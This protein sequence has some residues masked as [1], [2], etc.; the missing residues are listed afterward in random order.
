MP[1][2]LL[3]DLV[4]G[5]LDRV[6]DLARRHLGMDLS[7]VA[8][9]TE[10]KQVYRALRGDAS[11]FGCTLDDGP[12]L[13]ETYCRL[14]V[15]GEIPNA[16]PDTLGQALVRDLRVTAD[17]GIGSYVGVPIRLADGTLFGSFCCV[18]RDA[19]PVDSRDA[20]FL[21]M[22]AE[23]IAEQV[24]AQ[25][26]H[27]ASRHHIG[28]LLEG[29]GPQIAL[30]PI[31]DVHHGRLVGVEALSRFPV[32]YGPPDA[33]FAAAH[34]AGLGLEMERLAARRALRLLPLLGRDHYLAV[35]L[36]PS[37]A[38]DLAGRVADFPDVPYHRLVLEIT[39]HAAVQGYA[40]LRDR[41]KLARERGLRLAIDDAG[42]GY[43]SL[44]HVVELA[45]DIIKIDRS[46]VDGMATDKARRSVVTAFVALAQDIGALLVAEGVEHASDLDSARAL[47]ITCAQGYLLARPSTDRG[48]LASWISD[49][50]AIPRF[51]SPAATK[52]AW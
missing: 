11:A 40:D 4:D 39:E 31:V 16:I 33:V 2:A 12:P 3:N 47:G 15:T 27:D 6:L 14:M 21:S 13:S 50:V 49:G 37:V 34:E 45:P 25:R 10:G 35:N 44:H 42:A 41:L 52:V 22:L 19:H 28:A 24:Q 5:Q 29:V 23:L 51:T 30:Q 36:S 26:D 1:Q 17:P 8:E 32:E 18:S 9:F 48:A 38:Q 43:A 7:F 46:L 20:N